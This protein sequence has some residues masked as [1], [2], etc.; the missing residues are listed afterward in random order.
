MPLVFLYSL[1]TSE[2][3][4]CSDVFRGHR[5]SLVVLN[6]WNTLSTLSHQLSMGT[7]VVNRLIYCSCCWLWT[8]NYRLGGFEWKSSSNFSCC[9][10][11]SDFKQ[12]KGTILKSSVDYIRRLQKDLSR[13]KQFE[14]RAHNL[15]DTNKKL[16]LRIQ[17][18]LFLKTYVKLFLKTY[19]KQTKNSK[20]PSSENFFGRL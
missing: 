13:Y 9:C 12:N 8:S 18:R 4:W 11:F 15:E 10:Y 14:S 17:V 2:N 19:V 3:L 7:L 16:S 5:K 20:I 6:E 1:K